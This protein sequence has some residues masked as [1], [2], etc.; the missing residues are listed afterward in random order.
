MLEPA[1]A[2]KEELQQKFAKEIY[3]ERWFL[4]SGR[5]GNHNIPQL[6]DDDNWYIYAVVDK[7]KVVGYFSYYMDEAINCASRFALYSFEPG[8][9]RLVI[10]TFAELEQLVKRCHRLEWSVV[11]GNPAERAYDKFCK[12]HNGS[13]FVLHDSTKDPSGHYRNECI[14]EIV[15]GSSI[16]EAVEPDRVDKFNKASREKEMNAVIESIQNSSRR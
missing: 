2:Y 8:N 3:T 16:K 4:Y 10:D 12:K 9:L 1:I 11:Q 7:G 6:T 15:T 14:Y 5:S 13:K